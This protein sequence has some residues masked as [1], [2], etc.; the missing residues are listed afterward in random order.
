MKQDADTVIKFQKMN[1]NKFMKAALKEAQKAFDKNEVPVGCVIVKDNKIIARAHNL[2][3][4]KKSV[5]AHAELIAIEKANKKLNSWILDGCTIY[6]TLEPCPMCAGAI[7]QSRC[8]NLV[9]GAFEPKFGA[10]G[11]IVNLLQDTNFNHQV[12]ITSGVLQEECSNIL[13]KFFQI[14]RQKR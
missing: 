14:L 4:S 1:N 7:L 13:K 12:K 2:R 8:T 5:L 3:E 6:V 10:C 11:S 9:F